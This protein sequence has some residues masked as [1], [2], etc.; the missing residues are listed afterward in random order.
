MEPSLIEPQPMVLPQKL[1]IR[2]NYALVYTD[3][4]YLPARNSVLNR[5]Q[6]LKSAVTYSGKVTNSSAKRIR[7]AVS[8][9]VQKSK[10]RIIYNTVTK[11]T[12]SFQL[13]FLTLTIPDVTTN[14]SSYYYKILLKPFL[15]KIRTKYQVEDYVWKA[16]LQNRG[17]IHYHITL[18]QFI[19]LTWLKDTWNEILNS[20]NLMESY[21]AKYNNISPNSIDIHSVVDVENIEAYLCKYISK[22]E[23]DKISLKGKVWGCSDTIRGE[24]YFSEVITYS[25]EKVIESLIDKKQIIIKTF[26]NFSV[27]RFVEKVNWFLFGPIINDNYNEWK[28]TNPILRL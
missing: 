27:I 25:V 28:Q 17:S 24:N 19:P 6:N 22:V 20:N 18:N 4:S 14:D 26:D 5:L 7:K 16:E 23:S 2:G 8:I 21:K 15:R 10:K 13:S 11:K 9:F 3:F 12:Q 1:Q